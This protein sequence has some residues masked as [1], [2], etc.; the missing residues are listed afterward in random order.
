MI[1]GSAPRGIPEDFLNQLL[2]QTTGQ[3]AEIVLDISGPALRQA[4]RYRPFLIKPN[5]REL[6]EVLGVS[7]PNR[8]QALLHGKTTGAGSA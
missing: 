8:E 6:E 2:H 4:L 3:G 7:I 5:Q 1:S